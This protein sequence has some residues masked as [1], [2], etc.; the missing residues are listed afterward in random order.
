MAAVS[1]CLLTQAYRHASVLITSFGQVSITV[2]TLVQIDQLVH[3]LESP[4]FA[5]LRLQLLEPVRC[6]CSAVQCSQ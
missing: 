2:E 3:L 1:L 4:I 5:Y 6:V